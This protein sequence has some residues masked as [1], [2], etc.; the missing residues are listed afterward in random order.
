M[1]V[2]TL[3]PELVQLA[4]ALGVLRREPGDGADPRLEVDQAFFAD[5]GKQ[6]SGVLSDPVRRAAALE[7]AAALLGSAK[8]AAL[9]TEGA[10]PGRTWVPLPTGDG[11]AAG[12]LYLVVDASGDTVA[13][14]LAGRA[15]MRTAEVECAASVVVPMVATGPGGTRFL[16]GT[17]DGDIR[18][19]VSLRLPPAPG[20]FGLGGLRVGADV[21]THAL[22]RPRLRLSLTGLRLPGKPARDLDI[23]D[24]SLPGR[25]G[26]LIP[27]LAD[28]LT[29]LLRSRGTIDPASAGRLRL[30]LTLFGLGDTSVI[31]PLPLAELPGSGPLVF[32][33]WLRAVFLPKPGEPVPPPA[34]RA[35]LETLG[36]LLGL[37]LS[38]PL[39][40]EGTTASPYLLCLSPLPG[41]RVCV[42]LVAQAADDGLE[43]RLGLSA[44]AEVSGAVSAHAAA[45]LLALR[46]GG[47]AEV[48]WLPE[49]RVHVEVSGA[50]GHLLRRP[51]PPQPVTLM[52]GTLSAG[53]SIGSDRAVR[54]L[55]EAADVVLD[56]HPYS[57][58]DLSSVEALAAA[59][60]QVGVDALHDALETLFS[61]DEDGGGRRATALL[62][63]LALRKPALDWPVGLPPLTE[64]VG[65]PAYALLRYHSRVLADAPHR[66]GAIAAQLAVLVRAPAP[67]GEGSAV[68][69]WVVSVGD[70]GLPARP[71]L[72]LW[73]DDA[74]GAPRLTVGVRLVSAPLPISGG[75]VRLS[76]TLDAVRLTLPAVDPP[77][78][79]AL[80]AAELR[81]AWGEDLSFDAGPV[82]LK[83]G[84]L[85]LAA[86][87]RQ[88]AGWGAR[89][90]V[91]GAS[92]TVE[93]DEVALPDPLE[94][95]TGVDPLLPGPG[96]ALWP[97]LTRLAG[98]ALLRTTPREGLDPRSLLAALLG[99]LPARG[100]LRVPGE[101][102]TGIDL[103]ALIADWPP[104]PLAGLVTEPVEA[105]RSWLG[106]VLAGSGGAD[107]SMAA[108]ALL[109]ELLA[110]GGPERIR[111]VA[112]AGDGT[113]ERPWRLPLDNSGPELL[114][115]LD[116]DGPGLDGL[117]EVLDA[118]VPA[119]LTAAL[120]GSAPLPGIE[121]LTAVLSG[122]ARFD[123]DLAEL[124]D[125]RPDSAADLW[126]LLNHAAGSD[127]LLPVSAQ[128]LPG[129]TNPTVVLPRGHLCAP[130]TFELSDHLP[131]ADPTRT[132]YVSSDLP[133]IRPW[134]GQ[135]GAA[136]AH[137]LDLRT[138]GL[139]AES[140][141]LG[142]L[143]ATGPWYVLLPPTEEAT[144]RL[145]RA[146]A[147][148]RRLAGA[149]VVLVA[150]SLAA[151]A[152]VQVWSE[153]GLAQL[154]TLGG[155]LSDTARPGPLDG[156]EQPG[157][158]D[159]FRLLQSLVGL[160][161]AGSSTDGSP[162]A[163]LVVTWAAVTGDAPSGL[164]S[165]P[166]PVSAFTP[167][168]LPS[169]ASAPVLSVV[170]Q[171]TREE[172]H[173]ALTAL[174]AAVAARARRRLPGGGAVP[175]R[176]RATH[177]GLGLSFRSTA[178]AAEGI[179]CGSELRLDAWR[180]PLPAAQRSA[181][182]ITPRLHVRLTLRRPGGWL[183]DGRPGAGARTGP[184]P[185]LRGAD[186]LVGIGPR[187]DDASVSAVLHD[188]A[189]DGVSHGRLAITPH[190]LDAAARR[191]LGL[192]ADTLSPRPTAGP[193][194]DLVDL[195]VQA[196][197][198]VLTAEER[199]ELRPDTLERV[200]AD[201][202]G[203]VRTL[204]SDPA[205]RGTLRRL[206][207]LP[208]GGAG[209]LSAGGLEVGVTPD[210]VITV[211]TPARGLPLA[212]IA[213]VH[214]TLVVGPERAP[215][216]N[217]RVRSG[218][219]EAAVL[220]EPDLPAL[221]R[222]VMLTTGGEAIR[223][224]LQSL[225]DRGILLDPLLEVL[226]L[227]AH[228][229]Q[230]PDAP[231]SVR[232]P[233][234]LI[235]AP[236]R[237]L[238]EVLGAD[239]PGE[240]FLLAPGHL[241]RLID[242]VAQLIGVPGGLTALSLPGGGSVSVAEDGT[243]LEVTLR[244]RDGSGPAALE[245]AVH[246]RVR[247]G[248]TVTAWLT[249][250]AEQSGPGG[251]AAGLEL[252]VGP[253][254]KVAARLTPRAGA[255][256]LDIP[257]YPRTPG[258]G[259]L[260]ELG[261]QAAQYALP[262]LLDVLRDLADPADPADPRLK[263][264]AAAL[265]GLLAALELT[266]A[267]G[268]ASI[269]Q[270]KLLASAPAAEFGA[271]FRRHPSEVTAALKALARALIGDATA[272]PP[273]LWRSP[274]GR[275]VVD[276]DA[277]PGGVP[278]LT[279]TADG[280][281]PVPGTDA[282]VSFAATTAG[283]AP[284]HLSW[285]V[286]DPDALFPGPVDLMPFVR[287]TLGGVDDRV[288]AGLWLDP[289]GTTDREALVL[290]LPGSPTLV[291]RRGAAD[292]A[293]V[294]AAVPKLIRRIAV[295]LAA[296]LALTP[297][298]VTDLLKVPVGNDSTVGK[299]LHS[300]RILTGTG[301]PPGA[302]WRLAD[303]LLDAPTPR[304][305]SALAGFLT[306]L[307]PRLGPVR[308]QLLEAED[309]PG[310]RRY[311]LGL[312]L[313]ET[314]YPLLELG[315]V[316][317]ALSADG[318]WEPPAAG[319]GTAHVEVWLGSLPDTLP[320]PD[321]EFSPALRLRGLGLEVGGAKG[322]LLD[323][324]LRIDALSLHGSY[325]RDASG[326]QHAGA[327][328][329]LRGLA[330]PFGSAGGGTN[331]VAAKILQ[332]EAAGGDATAAA[333]GFDPA[334][335]VW[336]QGQDPVALRLSAG[337]GSGPWWLSVEKQLGPLYLEQVGLSVTYDGDRLR[338][339]GVLVDGGV[340]LGGL[341]V[342]VDDL[343]L[344]VP[345]ATPADPATWRL[346]LAG[347]A[348]SYSGPS[349]S[350]VGGLRRRERDGG[351]E[352]AGML[353]V[354]AAGFGLT[355]VGA[356]GTYP[357]VGTAERYT[358]MFGIATIA[359]P[360]GGPPAF[361]ITG[362]GAGLGLNRGL[363]L[364]GKVTDVGE[365]PL[366]AAMDPS[367]QL[368]R[369]P[370][371]ALDSMGRTF[372]PRRGAFWLA[373]GVRF[374]SFTVVESVAV[375]AVTFDHDVEVVLLGLC[376][377]ELPNPA[378]PIVS[379]ELALRAR[380]SAREAVL[381]V[382]AQLTD[383]SWLLN[384]DCRLSGG[385]AMVIW[386]RTGE[387]VLSLGGYH[388]RFAK[389]AH[390]P[391]VPR[392]G[393]HWRVSDAIAIKG[394][395]YFTLTSSCVMAG[396]RVEAAFDGG[397]VQASFVAGVDA[398]VSW[399]PFFYDVG[400]YVAVSARLEIDIR[401][402]F[403][404]VRITIGFSI[405]AQL[406]VQGP[407]VRGVAVLD[408]DVSKV[409][410]AFGAVDA[411]GSPPPL[412]WAAFHDK[413]LVA[414]DPHGETMSLTVRA[415]GA[416]RDPGGATGAPED[417]SRERPL[418]LT[419]EFTLASTTRTASNR[420][421]G[422]VL[423]GPALDLGPMRR[424]D[425]VSEHRVEMVRLDADGKPVGTAVD[426]ASTA[427]RGNVPDGVWRWF[428]DVELDEGG[429]REAFT[430]L[431]LS[432]VTRLG[433]GLTTGSVDEVDPGP[434]RPLPLSDERDP[435]GVRSAAMEAAVRW[436]RTQSG[437]NALDR[438]T[439]F[440]VRGAG[441]AAFSRC[442]SGGPSR[443][444]DFALALLPADR[445]SPPRLAR[446]TEGLVTPARPPLSLT[447]R[448]APQQPDPEPP[449][450]APPVLLASL[451]PP[452][453][454]VRRDGRTTVRVPRWPRRAAPTL[455]E[456]REQA[457][458]TA[459]QLFTRPALADRVGASGATARDRGRRFSRSGEEREVLRGL[460][461]VDRSA[462]WLRSGERDT[463]DGGPVQL[464]A[465]Q[466][467]VWRLRHAA[468]DVRAERPRLAVTGDQRVRIVALD[469]AG[470][471]LVDSEV[472]GTAEVPVPR[473]TQLLALIGLGTTPT[474]NR[475]RRAGLSGWHPG[476]FGAQVMPG[477][478]LV[479][480]ARVSTAA[481]GA[482]RGLRPARVALV[483]GF[484]LVGRQGLTTTELPASTHSVVVVL[485]AAGPV[486]DTDGLL[487]GL[488]GAQRARGATEPTPPLAVEQGGQTLLLYPVTPQGGSPV[489]VTTGHDERWRPSGVLGSAQPA[490]RVARAILRYG[491]PALT[492]DLAGEGSSR[493]AVTWIGDV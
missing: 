288:E 148:F 15:T 253:E 93:G 266:D 330:L 342:G 98:L 304:V 96:S 223:W 88:G 203:L 358:S 385:F 38:L 193:V 493:S 448:Q 407:D 441:F 125:E 239:R 132:V 6:L 252:E 159:A 34:A 218:Q 256:R 260:A 473:G 209:L 178:A 174:V 275:V 374:T 55:L 469:R 479:P 197:V 220:P 10:Q 328:L 121:R 164:R 19:A 346:G 7:L 152:A 175:G 80:T 359:A 343:A 419:S 290:R 339:V 490:E 177:L 386:F 230:R 43:L 201:P 293:E 29:G 171:F 22:G 75:A 404:H 355:A 28:L 337:G 420:A 396:A 258:L 401:V 483:T 397:F 316:V 199:V 232:S 340:A 311:G 66:W 461:S 472:A 134:P 297:A 20:D 106:D 217:L 161:P 391:D 323:Q 238:V 196:G 405:A 147:E 324:G 165:V 295:P 360:I 388:P 154:V 280:L 194:R 21:P 124:L 222:L 319:G 476:S 282:E 439:E 333:P 51:A 321:P 157:V 67:T 135:P 123:S 240:P 301:S 236:G 120:E 264:I 370:M 56:G 380:F 259:A 61:D 5:P 362:I 357:V 182:T 162:L 395:S 95:A 417:G 285:S 356:Y 292:S 261:Q 281:H 68:D 387:F 144:A 115:W 151:R 59:A 150:H 435:A 42:R 390:Y 39:R 255:P 77:S 90:R 455:A 138:P 31:P 53:F 40:G 45:D 277:A 414:G 102:D 215:A 83:A 212:G 244:L 24:G 79:V 477:T 32:A 353:K 47:G 243:D 225:R 30:L 410:V 335:I 368:V 181:P 214:G 278:R 289:P 326:F 224:G 44:A 130:E 366:V 267:D 195:L 491:L 204:L 305:L 449:R 211:S 116:P 198:A 17:A 336:K 268:A 367:S 202:A 345:W 142:G 233:V 309:G 33:D 462:P 107:R 185:R 109:R 331:P 16:P 60:A 122:A 149:P 378:K 412:G 167:I 1:T 189:L 229:P 459:A 488:D 249:L 184:Q 481:P 274:G 163:E 398:L 176:S 140:F 422:E 183:L 146:V 228:D 191:F 87:W 155:P 327:R 71:A 257:L 128:V 486:K 205:V 442:L 312:E 111:Q 254:V 341:A 471:A 210:C 425:V 438:A 26:E 86:G 450:V 487:L 168:A 62:V 437:A 206:A 329:E 8:D 361:F 48:L 89:A 310:Q 284:C 180:V 270:L 418:L 411:P 354:E 113:H 52:V 242:A 114:V 456:A 347:L 463:V 413:Y 25:L 317:V 403:V 126:S 470:A 226:G 303:G 50:E 383:N 64:I 314:P 457:L 399:D 464:G 444:S 169:A 424:V 436:S 227:L 118:L 363:V 234:P 9:E 377:M 429:V 485:S 393:I 248:P 427:V 262:M 94:L 160:L 338:E 416:A 313:V 219:V 141:G 320:G 81:L 12:R 172:L 110:R 298:P 431:V 85:L 467:Q 166:F 307:A 241:A 389:P 190:T 192:L 173:G 373:A 117:S 65:N 306:A 372:P 72:L 265:A 269:E 392:L 207:G 350:V 2:P 371:K 364:P 69:P 332:P 263:Q 18:V 100:R 474:A 108:I 14:S 318:S 35:W 37:P 250:S 76:A 302:P 408:L 406:T 54:L 41:V 99:W 466:I 375:L 430:G 382:E 482:K 276:L 334:L 402:W 453:G 82:Q 247:P 136:G 153:G 446:I 119:D 103:A 379:I 101:E 283:L 187:L 57:R 458:P 145:R 300:A 271:R 246:W 170:T 143:A 475:P 179:V 394:E 286:V 421:G 426:L 478:V 460:L 480:G 251:F 299:V 84:S 415:G 315:D 127:G 11:A 279:V 489:S 105:V 70:G 49:V 36:Q 409:E 440:L 58:L 308:L 129:T 325:A 97:A 4:V 291:H 352:Y 351:V 3:P 272:Q 322:P 433:G 131:G 91:T 186:L 23:D 158:H 468:E 245:S 188:A 381:S 231:G 27:L 137:L 92:V 454:P 447:P 384:R 63:L 78:A 208:D 465:G 400:V 445:I 73:Q 46:L 294:A 348:V 376:R 492:G 104:L 443:P 133:G 365:F 484:D 452:V 13:L 423:S 216:L 287:F 235:T 139:A 74:E 451:R 156:L 296:D 432:A 434:P 200:I 213:T 349:V 369:E 344:H 428:D 112:V 237:R 221:A 273:V